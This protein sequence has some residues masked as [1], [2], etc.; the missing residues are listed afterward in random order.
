MGVRCVVVHDVVKR[1]G[2]VAEDTYD[3]Y[4]QDR[5]GNVW[6]FGEDTKEISAGGRVSTKGSW[7]GG[8]NNAQPGIIMPGNPKPG[9][10]YRQEYA[11]GEAEDMGQV[12]SVGEAVT[13]PFGTF[14]DTVK[15]KDY[16]LLEA[17]NEHKWYARGVGFVRSTATGGDTSELISMTRK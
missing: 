13:V 7:V 11:P 17:G 8:V 1:N 3:W 12:V 14:K 9:E 6:Y 10:P 15:T 2:R 16:S 5:D 4:A